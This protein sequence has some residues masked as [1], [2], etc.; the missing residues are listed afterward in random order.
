MNLLDRLLAAAAAHGHESDPDHEV[1]D[2]QA[3][4]RSCWERLTAEQQRAVY[5]EHDSLVAEWPAQR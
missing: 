2:L 1:G 3:I 4:L 5:E